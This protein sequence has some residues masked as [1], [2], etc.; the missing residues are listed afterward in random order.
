ML[1]TLSSTP[2]SVKLGPR[3]YSRVRWYAFALSAMMLTGATIQSAC[4]ADVAALLP[5]AANSLNGAQP[6]LGGLWWLSTLACLGLFGLVLRLR[7]QVRRAMRLGQYELEHKIGEGGMGEVYRARHAMLKRPTAVKLLRRE[8]TSSVVLKRFEREVRLTAKLTHPNI[9][10]VFDYGRTPDGQFYYAMELLEGATLDEA[11]AVS[12]ALPPSRAIHVLRQV[13]SALRE[14]HDHGLIHRDI[15]PSNVIIDD[16]DHAK[17][18]DFGLVKQLDSPGDAHLTGD[19][20]LTGTPLYMAPE[21]IRS[22]ERVDRRS[23]IYAL[24]ALGYYLVCGEHVFGSG[25]LIEVCSGHLHDAPRRPSER[26]GEPLPVDLE[27]LLLAC[28]DKDPAGRPQCADEII[29]R[30]DGCIDATRWD[31]HRAA[32]WW[33]RHG[34]AVNSRHRPQPLDG[35]SKIQVAALPSV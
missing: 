3:E 16:N 9:V 28:L 2:R 1:M 13:A 32:A 35:P 22:P 19:R 12:G 25:S 29:D 27:E 26:L 31:E 5:A 34:A 33:S 10:T 20:N 23:D 8:R 11:V 24:G 21:M 15:K 7:K 17:L 4:T 6:L 18:L 14:A 30:L